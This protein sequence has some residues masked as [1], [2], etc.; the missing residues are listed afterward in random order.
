MLI[1]T[2]P[3]SITGMGTRS[4]GG[5]S[6]WVSGSPTKATR[7]PSS[8]M[9]GPSPTGEGAEPSLSDGRRGGGFSEAMHR[10]ASGSLGSAPDVA[11]ERR[12]G[13]P[14]AKAQIDGFALETRSEDVI[15]AFVGFI[16]RNT[17]GATQG[18]AIV[19]ALFGYTLGAGTGMKAGASLLPFRTKPMSWLVN[20]SLCLDSN[21]TRLRIISLVFVSAASVSPLR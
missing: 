9:R 4:D 2:H 12:Q 16:L 10:R 11:L 13:A 15:C 1:R 19:V 17:R 7:H 6:T 21:S 5:H 8:R 18:G 20:I 3:T 14:R